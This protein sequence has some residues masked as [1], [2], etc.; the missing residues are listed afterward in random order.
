VYAVANKEERAIGFQG[1]RLRILRKRAKLSQEALAAFLEVNQQEVS[2]WEHGKIPETKNITKMLN[3]FKVRPDYLFNFS[4][5]PDLPPEPPPQPEFIDDL[6]TALGE[7]D[8]DKI[9]QILARA[10]KLKK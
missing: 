8:F 4:D 2:E 3:Y 7:N 5:D 10:R 6:I 1:D 9:Q